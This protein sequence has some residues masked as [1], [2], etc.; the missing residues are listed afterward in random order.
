MR[1]ENFG[2]P[3]NLFGSTAA[4]ATLKKPAPSSN[5]YKIVSVRL[6]EAEFLSFA[7]QARA[8]DMTNNMDLR[9]AA[10]RIARFLEIDAETRSKHRRSSLHASRRSLS[11]SMLNAG[12][13]NRKRKRTRRRP[14]RPTARPRRPGQLNVNC[15]TGSSPC[16]TGA[17]RR[18]WIKVSRH[19]VKRRGNVL[20]YRPPGTCPGGLS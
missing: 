19:R 7:E 11:N 5:G 20:R 2:S 10:R 18:A 8:L 12:K 16:R 3:A 17:R 4:A 9:V 1:N 14:R 6:R 15:S 13:L